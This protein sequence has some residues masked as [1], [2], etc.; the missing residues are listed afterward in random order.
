MVGVISPCVWNCQS[1]K[2]FWLNTGIPRAH[3]SSIFKIFFYRVETI[4]FRIFLRVPGNKL[5]VQFVQEGAENHL[6]TQ[7][8]DFS[9]EVITKAVLPLQNCSCPHITVSHLSLQ[10]GTFRKAGRQ[11]P[12]AP[13]RWTCWPAK[14]TNQTVSSPRRA[15]M[16]HGWFKN[17][18]T[19]LLTISRWNKGQRPRICQHYT[20][21]HP[22]KSQRPH[23]T[24]WGSIVC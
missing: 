12:P 24:E 14:G 23:N 7:R 3:A 13:C 9:L 1:I 16:V 2:L 17:S 15:D 8:E 10:T 4:A 6:K 20:P 19:A 21:V 5:F 18:D 22:C 11:E